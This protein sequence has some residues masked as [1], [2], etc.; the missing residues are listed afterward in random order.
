MSKLQRNLAITVGIGG[1]SSAGKTTLAEL[2]ATALRGA[3]TTAAH[4]RAH[5]GDDAPAPASAVRVVHQDDFFLPAAQQRWPLISTAGARPVVDRDRVEAVRFEDLER[6]L[7]QPINHCGGTITGQQGYQKEMAA[8]AAT[9]AERFD[10]VFKQGVTSCQIR[11]V[12]GNLV[13]ARRPAEGRLPASHDEVTR[14]FAINARAAQDRV[15]EAMDVKL[16]LSVPFEVAALR[17]FSRSEYRD[18]SPSNPK[19]RTPEQH[20]RQAWYFEHAWKNHE[21]Y[22]SNVPAAW[23]QPTE[24]SS[25]EDTLTWAAGL[26]VGAIPKD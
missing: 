2:L 1:P 17:R 12:K 13:L 21:W 14:M 24:V 8:A 25:T 5:A 10:A 23:V 20:W 19:G 22:H 3:L 18:Q 7:C 16:F 9:L 15:R 4:R 26:V 6:E 11:I